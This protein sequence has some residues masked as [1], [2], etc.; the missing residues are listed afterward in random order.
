MNTTSP[1]ISI[2]QKQIIDLVETYINFIKDQAYCRLCHKSRSEIEKEFF[3]R[4]R[5]GGYRKGKH[6]I[7]RERVPITQW[8]GPAGGAILGH[9]VEKHGFTYSHMPKYSE[10][11]IRIKFHSFPGAQFEIKDLTRKDPF[12]KSKNWESEIK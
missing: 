9:L 10:P 3:Y 11:A 5:W 1:E 8:G 2:Q 6:Q 12:N 7:L 4:H